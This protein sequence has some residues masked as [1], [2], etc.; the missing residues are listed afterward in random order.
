VVQ[1]IKRGWNKSKPSGD[2]SDRYPDNW[3]QTIARAHK[4]T[5]GICCHCCREPSKEVHHGHYRRLPIVFLLGTLL[6]F[7]W[8][9][10]VLLLRLPLLLLPW[11]AIAPVILFMPQLKIKGHEIIGWDVFPVC[12]STNEPGTCHHRLHR[13]G[14]WITDKNNPKWGNHNSFITIWKLR[15]GWLML[16]LRS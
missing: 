5:A 3:R 15:L 8:F 4:S 13:K 14:N 6:W 9:P 16:K 7:C 10:A 1:I 2:F 12:G 11:L